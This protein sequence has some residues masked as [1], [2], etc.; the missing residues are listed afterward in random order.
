VTNGNGIFADQNV[1]NQE[2]HDFLAFDDSKR[3]SGA[4]Q[5]SKECGEGFCQ[6]HE[7]SAIVG[8]VGDRLELGTECLLSL[9]KHRHALT[10]LL[11]RHE[12]FLVGIEQSFHIL[13]NMGQLP[14][15]TLLTFSCWIRGT[16]CYQPT[17]KLLLYQSWLFQ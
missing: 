6:A 11:D 9:T 12:S 2:S 14:L 8:L 13:A 1:F 3:F 5:P 16:R 7:S 15:Q 17:I 4:A 10:Q